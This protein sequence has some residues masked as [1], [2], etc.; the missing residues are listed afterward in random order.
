VASNTFAAALTSTQF[1]LVSTM[2]PRSVIVPGMDGKLKPPNTPNETDIDNNPQNIPQVLYCE[3][4]MPSKD[5]YMSV[6]FLL[7]QDPHASAQF[8]EVLTLRSDDE[9]SWQFS[10]A[11]GNNFVVKFFG[12]V[13]WNDLPDT[14]LAPGVEVSIAYVDGR[15]FILYSNTELLEWDPGT[16][17]FITVVPTGI[18]VA[19]MRAICGS[20][21]HM[22][23][24]TD[25]GEI[26]WSS[27][28]DPTDFVADETTGAGIQIPV[29][30]RGRGNA[31]APQA[32]GFL[33]FAE[34]NVIAAIYTH[35][36]LSPW[37]FREVKNSGG[38]SSRRQITTD[39]GSG[40][41]YLYG[42]NGL[43]DLTLKEATGVFPEVSDFLG[44]RLFESFNW[45]T[46]ALTVTRDTS[47][48]V[49]LAYI[50]GRYLV[51]SYGTAPLVYTHAL[52]WD[53]L[54]RR[55][56]KIKFT[57]VDCFQGAQYTPRQSICF[58]TAN[59][60]V[61]RALIDFSAGVADQGVLMLGRYQLSR[62]HNICS[63][64]VEVECVD[65]VSN[66][67]VDVIASFDGSTP[68]IGF[69]MQPVLPPSGAGGAGSYRKFQRQV[70]GK[71]LAYVIKGSFDLS[72]VIIT[73][74]KGARSGT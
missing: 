27:I 60:A 9:Q 71:N 63:Q 3:N 12:F 6:G 11:T 10:P 31:L 44:G 62:G 43:Q 52:I 22:I 33:I 4:V 67:S 26:L 64:E 45:A 32:G 20:H 42:T 59:G 47:L 15:T 57:H 48:D 2:Q 5:G 1:P 25:I 38:S 68:S 51:L 19:D 56:G 70:E 46:N 55:W 34:F 65:G 28:T 72:S 7:A 37:L 73:V 49:K 13:P 41:T 66:F 24:L 29:D 16:E 39:S 61:Y 14:P 17:T 8:D 30:L 54:F 21:N 40:K 35:N 58:L 36:A 50:A 23:A 53:S 18:A 74:T 69:G